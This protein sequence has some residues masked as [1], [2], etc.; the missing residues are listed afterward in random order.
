MKIIKLVEPPCPCHSKLFAYT[1][2]VR[3]E[4]TRISLGTVVECDCGR[5]Y[6]LGDHQRDGEYWEQQRPLQGVDRG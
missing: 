2:Q 3:A 1:K 4:G 5:M 6:K